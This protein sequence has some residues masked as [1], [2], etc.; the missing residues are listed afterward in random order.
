MPSV[1]CY[2]SDLL[3]APIVLIGELK[4]VKDEEGN[5]MLF[6]YHFMRKQWNIQSNCCHVFNFFCF[7]FN[8]FYFYFLFLWLEILEDGP[9]EEGTW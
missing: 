5:W 1:W 2:L 7:S 9:E 8:I 6:Y 4:E 3:I